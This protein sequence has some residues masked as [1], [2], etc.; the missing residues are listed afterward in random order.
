M[1]KYN[2][3]ISSGGSLNDEFIDIIIQMA[4]WRI[5]DEDYEEESGDYVGLWAE[6]FIPI[7]TLENTFGTI[8]D[9]D[10]DIIHANIEEGLK[11]D[12][13]ADSVGEDVLTDYLFRAIQKPTFDLYGE[14]DA[15]WVKIGILLKSY[16]LDEDYIRN[17]NMEDSFENLGLSIGDFL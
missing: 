5:L 14:A 7:S 16:E 13:L 1:N 11:R 3:K 2:N 12:G 10:M 15:G 4:S 17:N 8:T 9:L 6:A